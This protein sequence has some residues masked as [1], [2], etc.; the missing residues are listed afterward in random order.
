MTVGILSQIIN[1]DYLTF[2]QSSPMPLLSL[3]PF[4][5]LFQTLST[6]DVTVITLA[7]SLG[8]HLYFRHLEPRSNLSLLVLLIF[9]PALL[10]FPI[11]YHVGHPL[12]SVPLAFAS[13][14]SFLVFFTVSYRLSPFHPLAKYPGPAIAKTSKWWGVYVGGRGGLHLY[15]K[16]L[17]DRYGDVVRVGPNELSVR[18]AS[19]IHAVLG[20]GGLPKGPRWDGPPGE[21]PSLIAQR[22]PVKHMHQRKPWNRAFS[23]TALKEY[24]AVLAKRARQL[25]SC[26]ED[27]VNGSDQKAGLVL[28]MAAWFSYFATDF[29]G[30]MAFGGGFELMMASGSNDGI[31]PIIESAVHIFGIIAHVTY[32][33]PPLIAIAGKDGPAQRMQDFCRERVSHRLQSGAHQKDLFYHLS[34]EEVPE[35]ERL[36]VDDLAMEGLLAIIAGSD[37]VNGSLSCALYY[38]V[39]NPAV[40][41]RL[42]E[43]VDAAFPS[44]EEPLDVAKLSYMEWLNACINET[45]RLQPPVPGGSGRI[46]GKGNGARVFGNLVIPE[47]TQLSL[48]T[49]SIHRDPRN[50]YTPDAFLPER[51]LSNGA[52]AGVHNTSA[53]FPFSYG[54][55]ICAGKNLALMEMRMLLCW[56]LR[57]FRFSKAPGVTYEGWEERI[58]DWNVIHND[59]LLVRISLRE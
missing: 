49:Y 18:D 17:H 24:E 2:S 12:A 52:P 31:R 51:W 46:L 42:Q 3:A 4:A 43:E 36:S 23:S 19:I 50:F 5:L 21:R 10:S 6:Y 26:I 15:Y 37:T 22:D 1:G 57:R 56:M 55:T 41:G 44:G 47:E 40:Y 20:Q 16:S 30:D 9:I 7:T 35:S 27:R 14:G 25:L 33:L 29:M 8:S 59:P 39:C 11:S 53:F 32:I 54:P 38:L 13:Y 58:Q 45:L 48:H 34:G 28:D